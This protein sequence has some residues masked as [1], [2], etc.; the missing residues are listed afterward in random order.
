MI[1][2]NQ[3]QPLIKNDEDLRFV[4]FGSCGSLI[5]GLGGMLWE[6]TSSYIP[7]PKFPRTTYF[8]D[9]ANPGTWWFKGPDVISRKL[10]PAYQVIGHKIYVLGGIRDDPEDYPESGEEPFYPWEEYLDVSPEDL[11]EWRWQLLDLPHGCSGGPVSDSNLPPSADLPLIKGKFN[12]Q[13]HIMSEI[14]WHHQITVCYFVR[15]KL[16]FR[17]PDVLN[18]CNEHPVFVDGDFIFTTNR[19]RVLAF[20]SLSLDKDKDEVEEEDRHKPWFSITVEGFSDT[21][22]RLPLGFIDYI[23]DNGSVIDD[24]S[25]FSL[26]R[27]APLKYE[28]KQILY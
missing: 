27:I 18:F 19:T 14:G 26:L 5:Y 1:L 21:S 2:L 7:P 17:I 12:L 10:S 15:D 6:T 23:C 28:R 8:Y 13:R 22:G 24:P 20:G 3:E 25:S 4:S 11:Q 16:L 9:T